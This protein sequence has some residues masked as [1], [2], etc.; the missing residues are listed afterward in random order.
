MTDPTE[1][2]SEELSTDDLKSVSG[3]YCKPDPRYNVGMDTDGDGFRKSPQ[4]SGSGKTL[5]EWK[6]GNKTGVVVD[7]PSFDSTISR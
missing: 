2:E 1:N 7:N 6:K 4:G 5:K 3:G